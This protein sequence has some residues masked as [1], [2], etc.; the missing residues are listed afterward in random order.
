MQ[1]KDSS[2]CIVTPVYNEVETLP[3]FHAR[4][5]KV[6]KETGLEWQI[7]Y[8]NDGSNDGSWPLLCE[9]WKSDKA[10]I[11]LI[12]FSRNFGKE[13]AMAAGFDYVD[14]DAVV[15]IDSDLQDPPEVIHDM[16]KK[17][18]A[19]SDVV[20]GTR[21]SRAG[22]SWFKKATATLFYRLINIL[23]SVPIPNDTGDFRLLSRRAVSAL[24]RF[25]EQHRFM[26]GMF[27]WIGYKQESVL[28]HR[29]S[30]YA[31]ETKWNYL[32][33]WAY[34]IEGITSFSSKPLKFST[35]LGLLL[36]IGAVIYAFTI[37]I[38]TLFLGI[39]IPGYASIM[40]VV[41]FLGGIQLFVLGLL[42][43]YLG[44]VFDE[45]KMRP[46]YFIETHLPSGDGKNVRESIV[47]E[48]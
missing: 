18:Q 37:V 24:R 34:A 4:T 36:S 41:L 43:E 13:A 40:V 6:L 7:L 28:Y 15:L 35:Y 8:I 27:S 9:L 48:H 30:R 42:G 26:K 39:D 46:L 45:C 22:E 1:H 21:I 23:T 10:H 38:K 44:R 17:W 25:K 3:E 29:D 20:Y 19:G 5:V 33:L 2:I 47:D 14:A 12:N 32:K 11:N 31:G 16:L